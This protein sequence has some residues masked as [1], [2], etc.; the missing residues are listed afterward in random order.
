VT[1]QNILTK[2]CIEYLYEAAYIQRWNDHIRPVGFTELDKQA[3]KM[4][5]LYVLARFEEDDLGKRLNWRH[6]IEG[7]I[8][9]FLHRIVL[10]DIKP[11]IYYQLIQDPETERK[12]N[13]WIVDSKLIKEVPGLS[14]TSFLKRM[15]LYFHLNRES[16]GTNSADVSGEENSSLFTAPATAPQNAAGDS[17][18][19][20]S[21]TDVANLH[22]RQ[23]IRA[24]HYL[25]SQWEFN[26]VYHFNQGMYGIEKT[27]DEIRQEIIAF[28]NLA[29]VQR[30]LLGDSAFDFIDLLGQLRFQKR[31]S[32]SPRIPET[33]VMGHELIVAILAYFC[34]LQLDPYNDQRIVNDFL[35]GLFHDLPEVLTRDIISPVKRSIGGLDDIIKDIEQKQVDK[36][37]LPLLPRAWAE[38]IHF[39]TQD[40]FRSRCLY[41][42]LPYPSDG[43]PLPL[44]GREF[45]DAEAEREIEFQNF[46]RAHKDDTDENGAPRLTRLVDGRILKGCDNL[47]AFVEAYMSIE[48]G[49]TSKHLRNGVISLRAK[50]KNRVLGG[51]DFGSIYEKFNLLPGEETWSEAKI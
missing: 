27:K 13:A 17:S 24:A 39:F 22:E 1:A 44:S 4:M 41:D 23:L 48:C 11:P 2:K 47:A 20:I 33:S 37:I 36:Q 45:D 10:T 51:I 30:Y 3:H 19:N 40:E 14:G 50:Y 16:L 8:F 15:R 46:V 28:R 32:Q 12:L 34:A 26:I 6:L 38:D 49:I 42:G 43:A 7:G 5:I 35:A 9:E 31:W 18:I 21:E 25:A 29:G